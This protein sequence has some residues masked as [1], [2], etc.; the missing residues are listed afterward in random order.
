MAN[1]AESQK[2]VICGGRRLGG[3]VTLQGAKNSALPI[4][5]GAVL[6]NGE[7]VLH[8][9]P[10]LSDV[11]AACRILSCLGCKCSRSGN[12]VS[13][14]SS[15]LVSFDVPGDLMKEMRSSIVF[16]GAIIGRM[17]R[18]KLSF[19]GGCE[20]GP[21]PIDLHLAA[22]RKMGV[23]IK[24][25]HGFLD[26]RAEK[27]IQGAAISLTFPSVGATENII[28]AAVT[29]KGITEIHN[30][31]REPEI[32]DLSE[33]L[34]KCGAKITG[35]GSGTIYIEGTAKLL[36]AE[37]EVIPDRIVAAT[38]MCCAAITRGEIM[39]KKTNYRH[40]SAIIPILEQI[41]C[42]V[43]L[44]DND[45]LFLTARKDLKA[46]GTLRTMVYPGF[47]TDTQPM[48]MALASTLDGTTV[49]V[50]TIF[51]NRFRHVSELL[52]LGAKISIEG[53]VAIVEGVKRL[54]A[55][56]VDSTDLRGGAALVTAALN[57]DG[58]SKVSNLYHIDRG[59]ADL[60]ADLKALGADIKR[61]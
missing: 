19:P 8:N 2:L 60:E 30:A 16:L 6:C 13:I 18:C 24:E 12:S 1:S 3:E 35:A 40:I 46:P 27:G 52:R 15:E 14:N 7:C 31:A 55:A 36:S 49:F 42:K 56:D 53:S 54:S 57:A 41:G 38:Y 50:E 29:A 59:Y 39:L 21:R 34:K 61:I 10:R 45:K 28:L 17:G 58:V 5:A 37:H 47:P 9:C 11:D 26:C 20:L 51:D 33:F 25:E 43:Y 44:Y 22:L 48:M 32:I 23:D 4:L